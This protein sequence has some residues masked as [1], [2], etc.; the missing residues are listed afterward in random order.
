MRHRVKRKKLSLNYDHRRSVV[1]NLARSLF[2]S[3]KVVT[4]EAKAKALVSFVEGL[5]AKAKKGDLV[6]RRTVYDCFQDRDMAN[7]IVG[8]VSDVFK[9]RDGGFTRTIKIKRRK[10]DNAVL[11]KV[12]FVEELMIDIIKTKLEKEKLKSETVKAKNSQSK[13]RTKK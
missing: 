12:E 3:G 13:R 11:V 6:A 4:T 7:L 10:G 2:L 9:D 5:I 8:K 1:K